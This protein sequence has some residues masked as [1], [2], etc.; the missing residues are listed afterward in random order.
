MQVDEIDSPL[1]ADFIFLHNWATDPIYLS[2]ILAIEWL[3]IGE[4]WV[5][6]QVDELEVEV[7]GK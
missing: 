6:K 1:F 2:K 5:A 4:F 7:E 3:V